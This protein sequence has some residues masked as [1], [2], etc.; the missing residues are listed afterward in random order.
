MSERRVGFTSIGT[1]ETAQAEARLPE[2]FRPSYG[3]VTGGSAGGAIVVDSGRAVIARS[4]ISMTIQS[5]G[6]GVV[7][8]HPLFVTVEGAEDEWSATSTDL[9]LVGEGESEISA[10]DDLRDQVSELYD[11]LSESRD[12]LGE[13]PHRQLRFLERLA[14]EL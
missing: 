9:S 14:G 13:L 4:A 6:N 11:V 2:A 3:E 12:D 5:L 1:S 10:V 8:V 7:F